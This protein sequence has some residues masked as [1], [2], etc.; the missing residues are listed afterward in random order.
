[1]IDIANKHFEDRY[2]KH[3]GFINSVRVLEVPI[4]CNQV[5]GIDS[6]ATSQKFGIFLIAGKIVAMLNIDDADYLAE[7]PHPSGNDFIW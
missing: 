5:V 3:F 2:R 4:A 7:Y 6:K 1:M